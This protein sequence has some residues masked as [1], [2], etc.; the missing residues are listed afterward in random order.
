MRSRAKQGC[1][2]EYKAPQPSRRGDM[3]RMLQA[4]AAERI[5]LEQVQLAEN[6][7][8]GIR[9]EE[10]DALRLL[11]GVPSVEQIVSIWRQR[12]REGLIA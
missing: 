9:V 11:K 12:K 3:R 2:G 6:G 1:G 10:R 5:R 8:A 4:A 7:S